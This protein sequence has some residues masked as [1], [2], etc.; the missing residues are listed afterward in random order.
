MTSTRTGIIRRAVHLAQT[1]GRSTSDGVNALTASGGDEVSLEDSTG[2]LTRGMSAQLDRNQFLYTPTA[3]AAD[4]VRI[5]AETDPVNT[6]YRHRGADYGV[7]PIDTLP[8]LLLKDHPDEWNAALN[9]ALRQYLSF[10]R[11]DEWT[12]TDSSRSIYQITATPISISD[13][14]E[15][16]QIWGLEVHPTN[17]ATNQEV[18]EDWADGR[19]TWR[20]FEDE[21]A[22]FIDFRS[23]V[24]P[25]T[26]QQLRLISMQPFPTLTDET[27]TSNVDELWAAQATLLVMADWWGDHDNPAD[28][29][30]IIGRKFQTRYEHR[31]ATILRKFAYRQ[32][33][34]ESTTVGRVSVAGRAGRG[35][36]MGRLGRRR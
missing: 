5:I 21:G 23:I 28:Q 4:R 2:F 35:G 33:G 6:A 16:S 8:Y 19:R 11:F 32:V 27:T 25:N 3:T 22:F 12:P 1:R 34:R 18:W 29:W 17:D 14:T 9:E 31:R 30:A 15:L 36:L 7:S 26:T 20:P 10:P 13:I 24:K